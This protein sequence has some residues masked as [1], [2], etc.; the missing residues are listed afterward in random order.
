MSNALWTSD[1][2]MNLIMA[3]LLE[4]KMLKLLLKMQSSFP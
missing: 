4:Y 2:D 3:Q 1:S